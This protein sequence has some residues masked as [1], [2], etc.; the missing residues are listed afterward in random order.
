M[1]LCL[2]YFPLFSRSCP[3]TPCYLFINIKAISI[4]NKLTLV[5]VKPIREHHVELMSY[6]AQMKW[7]LW[8]VPSLSGPWVSDKWSLPGLRGDFAAL[9]C[10]TSP[11]SPRW[12]GRSG[13]VEPWKRLSNRTSAQSHP[14]LHQARSGGGRWSWRSWRRGTRRWE[15]HGRRTGRYPSRRRETKDPKLPGWHPEEKLQDWFTEEAEGQWWRFLPLYCKPYVLLNIVLL[16]YCQHI[17]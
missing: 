14:P 6:T 7:L 17:D 15:G 4:V 9:G 1:C 2:K 11:V 3:A 10:F 13:R 5:S 12:R 16:W 8:C